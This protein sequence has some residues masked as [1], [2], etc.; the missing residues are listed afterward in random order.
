MVLFPAPLRRGDRVGVTSPSAG[1]EGPEAD[2]IDFCVR[3]LRE[4]GFDVVVGNLMDGTGVTS[5]PAAERA[6][7]LTAMLC[8]P[9]I[10]CVIPPWGGETGIDLVDL[11]DWDALAAA[12]PTWLV[13]FSDTSTFLVPITTRLGWATVHGDDLAD[14]PYA[15]PEGLLSWRDIVSG[16]GPHRQ[17]D[18]GLIADWW[19]IAEDPQATQWKSVSTGRWTLHGADSVHVSGRLIGGCVEAMCNLAG[20]PYGDVAAFGR[21]HADDGLIVYVEAAGDEAATI[22]RN[23]HGLRLAGWFEH[24]QAILIGRTNAPDHPKLTQQEAVIDALGRLGLPIVLD[25]EIGHVPPHLPLVNG[26]L[27]TLTF[28]GDSREIVQQLR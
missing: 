20:T 22:C 1:V 2:R 25:L 19:P 3:W 4:A 13:G 6:A 5:G 8:D 17:H 9:S 11:L 23:L 15:V 21:Q 26:A 14:T 24:A 10:K 18:S 7:E 27:A 16:T 12:D 28:D